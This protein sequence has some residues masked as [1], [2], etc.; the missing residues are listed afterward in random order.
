MALTNFAALTNEE[1]TAWK[2]DVWRAMRNVS[3][4]EH[5]TGEDSSSMIQ[6]ITELKKDEK[7]ARAVITLVTDSEGDGVAGDNTLEGNEEALYSFEQ[8]IQIDQ[9]RHAHKHKG[10]MADQRSLVNFRKEAKNNLAFWHGDRRDQMAILTLSGLAYTLKLDGTTRTGSQFPQLTFAADVTAPSTNRYL[11]WD[12]TGFGVNTATTQL[13]AADTPTW[14]MLVEAKAFAVNNYIR[15]ISMGGGI[16]CYNVFMSP[17]GIA[18]LKQDSDFITAWRYAKE[19]GES[20]PIFKGTPHGA[21]TGGILVDGLNIIE[22][23]HVYQPNTWGGGSLA[24]Q[25][26]LFC[27]AQALAYADLGAPSWV[28]KEFDYGNQPGIAVGKIL[29]FKKPVFRSQK[30]GTNE[31]YGVLVIDTAR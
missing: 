6:R 10:R 11:V 24:G 31:D 25:R 17:S 12:A 28:E 15:P 30:T 5:F 1:L 13:V 19:R 26:V 29:G 22:T 2:R 14:K 4:M 8:V 21:G 16:Y 7:G 3:F 9:L 23:R 20:N 27:G 18:K